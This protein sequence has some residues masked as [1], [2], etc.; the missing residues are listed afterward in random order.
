[1]GWTILMSEHEPD[2]SKDFQTCGEELDVGD[3]GDSSQA[4]QMELEVD[5]LME[6]ALQQWVTA[7]VGWVLWA[8]AE[9]VGWV[10]L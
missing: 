10:L 8:T 7:E 3:G 2:Q 6:Q 1:M 4:Y 9:V 5:C